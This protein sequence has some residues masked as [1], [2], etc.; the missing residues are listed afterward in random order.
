MFP[1]TPPCDS[2]GVC[3][4]CCEARIFDVGFVRGAD[5]YSSKASQTVMDL[6]FAL[7]EIKGQPT[8]KDLV[9]LARR[10]KEG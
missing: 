1:C 8:L 4:N 2:F 3:D 10:I 9:K 7:R 6:F 5:S